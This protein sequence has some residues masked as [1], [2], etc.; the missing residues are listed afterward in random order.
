MPK[1]VVMPPS[2]KKVVTDKIEVTERV[3]V[4]LDELESLIARRQQEL[5]AQL[6]MYQDDIRSKMELVIGAYLE[7][8]EVP[9]DLSKDLIVRSNDGKALLIHRDAVKSPEQIKAGNTADAQT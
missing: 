4:K 9:F 1:R 8:K 6:T 5:Q 7:G 3:A 2:A